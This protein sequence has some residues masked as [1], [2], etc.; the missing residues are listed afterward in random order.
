MKCMQMHVI[1]LTVA[2]QRALLAHQCIHWQLDK[3]VKL[4]KYNRHGKVRSRN[5]FDYIIYFN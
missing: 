1:A 2:V 5:H 4:T 3:G